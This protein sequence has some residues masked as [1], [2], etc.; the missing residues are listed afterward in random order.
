MVSPGMDDCQFHYVG[1]GFSITYYFIFQPVSNSRFLVPFVWATAILILCFARLI[2]S[3]IMGMLYRL[4]LGETR[5]LVVGSGRLGKMIMQHIV[6]NPTS[7]TTLL[8]SCM[9]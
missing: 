9:I 6:A 7:V 2:V 5:L 4:G 1:Y 8:A 3:S